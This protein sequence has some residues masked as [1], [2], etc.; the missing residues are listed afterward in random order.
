MK[1]SELIKKNLKVITI[2]ATVIIFSVAGVTYSLLASEFIPIG[3]VAETDSIG[4]NLT[5]L[6]GSS[7]S[8]VSNDIEPI[9]ITVLD[10]EIENINEGTNEE[11]IMKIQAGKINT[12]NN[13]NI[14]KVE[15]NLSGNS[16]NPTNTI[17]D[18]ALHDIDMDCELKKTRFGWALY[19]NNSL[20][21]YGNFSPQ[22]DNTVDTN[23][24]IDRYVL[25]ETQQD[26]TTSSDTYALYMWLSEK[27]NENYTLIDCMSM[28]GMDQSNFSGKS[29]SAT[30][31]IEAST[32]TKKTLVR[33]S[34]NVDSC[35]SSYL[36]PVAPS[37]CASNYYDGT[38]KELVTSGQV[39]YTLIGNTR[40]EAG[41]YVVIAKLEDGYAWNGSSRAD[42]RY[43]CTIQKRPIIITAEDQTVTRGEDI[44][45]TLYQVT[46]FSLVNGHYISSITLYANTYDLN[47]D[48]IIPSGV[49][50]LDQYG[51]DVTSNYDI[52]YNSGVLT[53]E[54]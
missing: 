52:T 24:T 47:A 3:V 30:L 42:K 40:T 33:E 21:S 51:K 4:V 1:L 35:H 23:D 44:D 12:I 45:D 16:N 7:N 38:Q 8:I 54:E 17:Y 50:I 41:T 43:L 6:N 37:G 31:K 36:S 49:I 32:K 2:M 15:F 28:N 9:N 11:K 25:T 20:L 22:F 27:C 5:Y 10:E 26:L 46:S 48:E 14:I 13:P 34:S 39:G 53:V 29:F 19:K 18:I